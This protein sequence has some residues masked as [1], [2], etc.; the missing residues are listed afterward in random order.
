MGDFRFLMLNFIYVV[1]EFMCDMRYLIRCMF[2]FICNLSWSNYNVSILLCCMP[3]TI[4]IVCKKSFVCFNSFV[5]WAKKSTVCVH[6]CCVHFSMLYLQNH[7]FMR[8][9]ICGIRKIICDIDRFTFGPMVIVTIVLFLDMTL[10][11]IKHS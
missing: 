11:R 9:I 10:P 6:F 4:Y 2:S 1:C 7:L 5:T 3:E 8:K